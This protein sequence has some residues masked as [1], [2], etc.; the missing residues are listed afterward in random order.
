VLLRDAIESLNPR[1]TCNIW[2]IEW[3]PYLTQ[4]IY[5]QLPCF[6]NGWLADFPDPHDFALPFYHTG[7]AFAAWQAYSNS[8][9]DALIDQAINTPDGSARAALYKQIQQGAVDDCPS[10][11]IDQPVGRHFERD[12]VV[13]WYYNVVY[14]GIYFYNLWKSYYI[15]HSLLDTSTQPTSSMLPVDVNYDGVI[16]FLDGDAVTRAFTSSY[17]PPIDSRWN[18]RCDINN[19]RYIG[20]GDVSR[21][22]KN[23]GNGTPNPMQ[24]GNIYLIAEPSKQIVSINYNVNITIAI[25]NVTAFTGYE[26]RVLYDPNLLQLVTNNTSQ[27]PGW[28]ST[29]SYVLNKIIGSQNCTAVSTWLKSG[30]SFTGNTAL[31]TFTFQG[32][33]RGNATLDI[34]TSTLATGEPMK[35]APYN[36][37]NC[38]VRVTMTGDITGPN[39]VPDNKVD[40]KDISFVARRFGTIPSSTLWDPNA[41]INNDG[42]V[43]IKDIS[44][45]ARH[46]GEYSP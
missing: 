40:I 28:T 38:T 24:G 34:S 23:L 35:A 21:V 30:S 4:A 37:V 2:P 1:Y 20:I 17:G 31:V 43:D 12:W 25:T 19:D 45:V 6:I 11:I 44:D 46:F 39:G 42:K 16:N 8:T 9:M 36:P 41:D 7:G 29:S 32:S 26:V 13:D 33:S 14:P 5:N 27:V 3:K 15:P 18:F 22:W 10:F